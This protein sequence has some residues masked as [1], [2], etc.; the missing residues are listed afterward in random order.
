MNY[1]KP[2]WMELSW[3][4]VRCCDF[5]DTWWL[6]DRAGASPIFL[7]EVPAWWPAHATPQLYDYWISLTATHFSPHNPLFFLPRLQISQATFS[8][9]CKLIA[10]GFPGGS[11]LKKK[12]FTGQCRRRKFDLWV[13]KIPWRR[14][15]QPTPVFLPGESYGQRTLVGYSPWGH[16][17]G[18]NWTR[19]HSMPHSSKLT[20][21]THNFVQTHSWLQSDVRKYSLQGKWTWMLNT[22]FILIYLVSFSS[23]HW[24]FFLFSISSFF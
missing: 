16:Q 15:W 10:K 13:R 7:P 22:N 14:K 11:L 2:N 21:K 8:S 5:Q 12:N 20:A 17:V 3:T 1:S 19:E 4:E 23:S 18:H 9:I 24:P 6:K